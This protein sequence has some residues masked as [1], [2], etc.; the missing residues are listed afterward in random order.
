[1]KPTQRLAVSVLLLEHEKRANFLQG[2]KSFGRG[3]IRSPKDLYHLLVDI[4]HGRLGNPSAARL[5]SIPDNIPE[6]LGNSLGQGLIAG[7]GINM[8]ASSIKKLLEERNNP[9]PTA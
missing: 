9:N 7:T 1:M 4:A 6:M 5:E 3:V 8:A 2:A